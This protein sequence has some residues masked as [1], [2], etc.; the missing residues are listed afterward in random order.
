MSL[1]VALAD[2][3]RPKQYLLWTRGE[4]PWV[5]KVRGDG[6]LRVLAMVRVTVMVTPIVMVMVM[7]VLVV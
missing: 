2:F 7:V 4:S 6:A 1:F 5:G 3:D